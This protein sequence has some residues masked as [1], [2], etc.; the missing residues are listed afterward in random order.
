MENL[1]KSRIQ[2]GQSTSAGQKQWSTFSDVHKSHSHETQRVTRHYA[3]SDCDFGRTTTFTLNTNNLVRNMWLIVDLAA[4]D[5]NYCEDVALALLDRLTYRYQGRVFS[6]FDYKNVCFALHQKVKSSECRKEIRRLAGSSAGA[7]SRKVIVPLY[8]FWS[9]YSKAHP[10]S[11]GECWHNGSSASKLE[12]TLKW[13]AKADCSTG[14]TQAIN[15]VDFYFEEI[16]VS[17][18]LESSLK[19]RGRGPRPRLDFE[20]LVNIPIVAGVEKEIDLAPLVSGGNLRQ[21]ICRT[22]EGSGATRKAVSEC[23]YPIRARLVINGVELFDRSA[24]MLSQTQM[25]EGYTRDENEEFPFAVTFCL[26]PQGKDSSG[27]L[28]HS[29]SSV[30]LYLTYETLQTLDIIGEYERIFERGT[31]GR[32]D[33][34]DQ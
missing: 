1:L 23:D 18:S 19:A 27:Y 12:V 28:P 9:S 15:A 24:P 5:G 8:N 25:L 17:P 13:A 14:G 2:R 33:K 3:L 22:H 26:N 30:S 21:I 6:D 32:I 16:L 20:H 29:N 4:A 31:N 11:T 7:T 10:G 34:K